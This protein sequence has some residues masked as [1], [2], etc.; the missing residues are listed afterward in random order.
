MSREKKTFFSSTS[1]SNSA[2]KIASDRRSFW[3][4]LNCFLLLLITALKFL[5]YCLIYSNKKQK[6]SWPKMHSNPN[7]WKIANRQTIKKKTKLFVFFC[8]LIIWLQYICVYMCGR[9]G[10]KR[11]RKL[12][13]TWWSGALVTMGEVSM[14]SLFKWLQH[15]CQLINLD[16][17]LTLLS[18]LDMQFLT[19]CWYV[20][21]SVPTN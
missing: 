1:Q 19:F 17:N 2:I 6:R 14:T 13:F 7:E 15:L 20:G 3:Y 16:Y 12:I 5:I 8:R 21:V 9:F 4:Q 10:N 18:S 11:L